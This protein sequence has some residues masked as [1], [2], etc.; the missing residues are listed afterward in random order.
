MAKVLLSGAL[1]RSISLF[2]L[3]NKGNSYDCKSLSPIDGDKNSPG[4]AGS[5]LYA[6]VIV[7]VRKGVQLSA[8]I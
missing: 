3:E 5:S 2:I 7:V 8:E 4:F 6:D 1:L